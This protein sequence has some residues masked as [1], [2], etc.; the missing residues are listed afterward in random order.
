MGELIVVA[1]GGN[2]LIREGQRGTYEE[3]VD[4]ARTMARCVGELL[5]A[6]WRVVVVHGNGPQVGNLA[7]AYQR[8]AGAVPGE[9]LSSLVAM[10]QG[11]LGN[12]LTLALREECGGAVTGDVVS[13]VTHVVVDPDHPQS[14]RPAKPI[15]AFFDAEEARA[16]GVEHGWAMDQDAGRGYRRFVVSP[17]PLDVVEGTAIRELVDKGH[18]VVACG[19]GGIPVVATRGGY[20]P[21]DGVVDKD[22]A[23]ELLASAL[24]ARAIGLVTSVPAVR[25]DFG[26]A[27]DRPVHLLTT[28]EA[29]RHLEGGQFPE[30]SMGPKVQAALRFLDR[31]GRVAAITTPERLLATVSDGPPAPAGEVGTRIVPASRPAR[32]S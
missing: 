23:A 14:R 1:L 7:M 8:A 32:V 16:L 9:P 17:D 21:F 20:R 10:T 28:E 30:G 13:L 5:R 3:Q 11:Q 6:G 4:N 24:G 25:L 31:G 29:Q 22:A 15:G 18:L 26:T 27:T 2:A 19:G 12:L